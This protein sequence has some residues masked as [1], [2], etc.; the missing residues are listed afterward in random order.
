MVVLDLIEGHF[1]PIDVGQL[2]E[3][4]PVGAFRLAHGRRIVDH[5]DRLVLR[6]AL[7]FDRADFVAQGA[8]GA[9]LDRGLQRVD[10]ILVLF[11]P[12]GS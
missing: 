11:E 9:V 10:H 5:V 1:R 8:A 3:E 4:L 6:L 2:L 7:V 12:R